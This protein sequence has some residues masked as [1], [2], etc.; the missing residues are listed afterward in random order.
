MEAHIYAQ[1]KEM[2]TSQSQWVIA[3]Q[4]VAHTEHAEADCNIQGC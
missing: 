3:Y 1:I 2:T 4:S